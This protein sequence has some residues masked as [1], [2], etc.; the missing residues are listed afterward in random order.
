MKFIILIF[1]ITFCLAPDFDDFRGYD[2]FM[3]RPETTEAATPDTTPPD[4]FDTAP[5]L[6]FTPPNQI[7]VNWTPAEIDAEDVATLRI[8]WDL[9]EYTAGGDS[10]DIAWASLPADSDT[11]IA[12]NIDYQTDN[13]PNITEAVSD[14]DTTDSITVTVSLIDDSDNI[15]TM[16]PVGDSIGIYLITLIPMDT[17]IY[18]QTLA[19]LDTIDHHYLPNSWDN[20]NS[21]WMTTSHY[22]E[23]FF[24]VR[25][26]WQDSNSPLFNAGT[27]YW[28]AP[29]D[30]WY[31]Y[32]AGLAYNTILA[33]SSFQYYDGFFGLSKNFDTEDGDT[34]IVYRYPA[35]Y[36]Q[37]INGKIVNARGQTIAQIDTLKD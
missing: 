34:L 8:K 9:D 11:V 6:E 18:D 1:L 26:P 2:D 21:A 22:R 14:A 15:V 24:D 35:C 17:I 19:V 36:N 33:D 28:F 30:G 16:A 27:G 13:F 32:F 20:P 12:F 4:S 31:N 10:I 5:V 7:T 37:T 23:F 3:E 29:G 25:Y